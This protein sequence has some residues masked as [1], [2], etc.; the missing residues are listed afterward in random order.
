MK[1][2]VAA[3]LCTAWMLSGGS[4]VAHDVEFESPPRILYHDTIY[5]PDQAFPNHYVL[6]DLG[7]AKPLGGDVNPKCLADRTVKLSF[8]YANEPIEWVLVDTAKTSAKGAWAGLGP[9]NNQFGFVSYIRAKVT[10]RN[11]GP[12]GHRHICAAASTV[13]ATGTG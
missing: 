12:A 3:V 6:G 13:L 4:A 9:G 1:R 11:I 2:A 8:D 10:P 5:P 7:L